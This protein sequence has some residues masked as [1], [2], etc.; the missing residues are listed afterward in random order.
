MLSAARLWPTNPTVANHIFDQLA[1]LPPG[2]TIGIL[3]GGQLG[4]M[5]SV[6]A[7]RLGMRTHVFEPAINCPAADVAHAVTRAEYHDDVALRAFA[8]SV[9][10]IT[11][12]F[13]N[14]PATALDLLDSLAPIRPGRRALAVSQDRLD[15]KRFISGLGIGVAPHRGVD[16]VADIDA[17]LDQ[18]GAGI[19]KTRQL[20]YDGK[21]QARV[22]PGDDTTAIFETLRGAPAIFE[23]LVAFDRELSVIVARSAD[24]QVVCFDPGENVHRDGI[25][26]TTSVPANVPRSVV[27]AAK[28]IAKQ[29]ADAFDYIGVMGVELFAMRDGGLIVNEVAPRVH[30]SGHWTIEACVVDQFQQHI[31][32]VVGWPLGDGKR[33]SDAVMTNLIGNEA[34]AWLDFAAARNTGVHLYGKAEARP[35]RKM[36]H[37]TQLR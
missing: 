3:G 16:S 21:G 18:F 8:Q 31:R 7:S 37:I 19:I 1:P 33:H 10:V 35:G 28:D 27:D 36:G 32:A 6:A 30:N 12:E 15:E 17:A 22:Q 25:L 23:A 34:D 20:G 2:S 13:E 4:R 14:V 5:L 24:G 11:Y 9:N 29:I 26:H